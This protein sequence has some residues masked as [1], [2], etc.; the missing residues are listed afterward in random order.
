VNNLGPRWK[1]NDVV[2]CAG[3]KLPAH[4]QDLHPLAT[5]ADLRRD[6]V[7]HSFH[8]PY[9]GDELYQETPRLQYGVWVTAREERQ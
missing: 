5:P 3:E 8:T 2:R 4:P 9:Y 1:H 7:V 6:R